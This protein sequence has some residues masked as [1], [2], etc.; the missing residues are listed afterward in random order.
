MFPI[1]YYIVNIM[2]LCIVPC[3]HPQAA[4]WDNVEL[5]QELLA[6]GADVNARDA[7]SR[8]ALHAAA[9]AER[10]ACLL[11]LCAAGADLD[12][13]SSTGSGGKVP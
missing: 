1:S 6:A 3:L 12:A 9:L 4:L 11:A 13:V 8:T 7:L 10:S 5:L 2:F